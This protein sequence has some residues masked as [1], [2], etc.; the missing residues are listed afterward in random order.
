MSTLHGPFQH[1]HAAAWASGLKGVTVHVQQASIYKETGKL[2]GTVL[3][4]NAQMQEMDM[5][6]QKVYQLEQTQIAIKQK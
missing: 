2:I 4:V 6:R 1:I 3:L 5:V